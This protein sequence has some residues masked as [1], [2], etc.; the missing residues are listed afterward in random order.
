MPYRLRDH[1]HDEFDYLEQRS[2]TIAEYEVCFY[3]LSRYS[4]A[5]ISTESERICKFV[6]GLRVLI[7]WLLLR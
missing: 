3:A 2:M 1:M 4:I 7:S 5:N 6:K